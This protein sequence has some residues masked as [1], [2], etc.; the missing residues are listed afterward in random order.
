MRIV[1]V[2]C[3]CGKAKLK[4][5]VPKIVEIWGTDSHCGYNSR[6]KTILGGRAAMKSIL[7]GGKHVKVR[8]PKLKELMSLK[9][10]IQ[11]GRGLTSE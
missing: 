4:E 5:A 2:T 7:H 9:M 10:N 3:P 6:S 11:R 8:R 1:L